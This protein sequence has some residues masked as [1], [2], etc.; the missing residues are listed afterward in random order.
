MIPGLI[1]LVTS[2]RKKYVSDVLAL[3]V[4]DKETHPYLSTSEFLGVG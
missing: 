2:P 3:D 4:I 1:L